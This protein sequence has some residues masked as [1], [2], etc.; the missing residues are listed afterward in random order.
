MFVVSVVDQ[1][2]IL[3]VMASAIARKL[4]D[5]RMNW[6]V[7]TMP[8]PRM[9]TGHAHS[10]DVKLQPPTLK[11][12]RCSLSL[13][14]HTS[15]DLAGLTT[16]RL[17]LE[18]P[19][20][21][22]IV[23]S[24]TGNSEFAL[25]LATTTSF[26][27]HPA[28]GWSAEFISEFAVGV[29]PD[30]A[31]DSYVTLNLDG[32]AS[33]P[34]LNP[35][36][37]PGTWTSDFAAGNNILIDDLAGSG[38]YV[39]PDGVNT[40][41]D[42]NNRVL[43]AQLTTDGTIY[44]QFRVQVF[45]QGDNINDERVD[46]A[47][48]Q[49]SCGGCTDAEACNYDAEAN[50]DDGSCFYPL[51]DNLDCDGECLA[52]EDGDGICDDEEIVGCTEAGACNYAADATDD[53][54]SCFF[55][56]AGYDCDGNCLLDSDG[57]GICNAFESLGCMEEGACNYDASATEEDGSC[58]YAQDGYDCDG[59]CLADA[60]GDGVCDQFEV[61]GCTD[62][63]ACNYDEANTEEDGSCDFCSAVILSPATP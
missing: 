9:K 37:L 40:A 17:D 29:F 4:A 24:F 43:F 34:E 55:A 35:T 56:E 22:D 57:D 19:N 59:V 62:A 52:D 2:W 7:T 54:G 10:A 27:Q 42:E 32:P 47:F 30:V 61:A 28:G 50:T 14:V 20:S 1:V 26:Y 46:I 25:E 60:D 11:A 5:V 41:V 18:T 49:Q 36:A 21:T 3:T 15:G 58:F 8:M 48:V 13:M 33:S 51:A 6:L 44:G 31:Y 23:T 53:D 16:Y 39:T 45:P 12:T 38:W 63:T